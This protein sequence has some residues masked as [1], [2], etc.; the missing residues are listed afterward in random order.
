MPLL[1]AGEVSWSTMSG[2]G[3][4]SHGAKARHTES[5]AGILAVDEV[6]RT[7]AGLHG[8]SQINKE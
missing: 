7:A 4:G 6:L 1:E 2:C 5:S 8:P 3:M